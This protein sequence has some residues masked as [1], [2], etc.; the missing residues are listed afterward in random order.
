MPAYLFLR[1]KTSMRTLTISPEGLSTEIGKIKAQR[2]WNYVKVVS[3][4]PNYVLIASAGG[5]AFF[6][7]D[8]A[9]ATSEQK[10]EFVASIRKWIQQRN[11]PE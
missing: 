5:N 9:F 1:G 11:F 7:P 10:S 8:R 3:E 2:P 6:I 4:S